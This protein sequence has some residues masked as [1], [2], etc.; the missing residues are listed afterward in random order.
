MYLSLSPYKNDFIAHLYVS[1]SAF[2][3][4]RPNSIFISI[5]SRKVPS[6]FVF[7]RFKPN[8]QLPVTKSYFHVTLKVIMISLSL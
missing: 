3:S 7:K 8:S 4:K 5:Y 1:C 6:K 2:H